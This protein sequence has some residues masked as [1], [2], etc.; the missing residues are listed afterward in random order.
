MM[1]VVLSAAALLLVVSATVPASADCWR[2]CSGLTIGGHCQSV[3][4]GSCGGGEKMKVMRKAGQCPAQNQVL[5][6][7]GPNCKWMCS[8]SSSAF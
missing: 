1:K 4:S 6:C 2:C 8:S 7:N 3:C 5:S